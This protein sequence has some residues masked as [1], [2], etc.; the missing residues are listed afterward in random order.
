LD[1]R[2]VAATYNV[3]RCVGADRRGDVGRIADVILSMDADVVALQEVET[4]RE[5][6]SRCLLRQLRESGYAAIA[7]PTLVNE[8]HDYGNVLLS[9]IPVR[10]IER[11]DISVPRREPRGAVAGELALPD[12][13][14][15]DGGAGDAATLFCLATHLGLRAAERRAQISQIVRRIDG[16]RG[17]PGCAG[18]VL[19]GDFNE[20]LPRQRRLKPFDARLERAPWRSTFPSRLPLLALDRIWFSRD[21]RLESV[22]AIS[23]AAARKASDHLPLR[24]VLCLAASP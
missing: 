3:H 7:G 19:L 16:A 17:R 9:R 11:T 4:P 22:E 20:W 1:L 6:A 23:S 12:A 18:V 15:P 13:R 24:A 14:G 21:L 8:R 10:R 5:P 2:I